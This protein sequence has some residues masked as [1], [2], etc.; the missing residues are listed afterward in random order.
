MCM[1][2]CMCMHMFERPPPPPVPFPPRKHNIYQLTTPSTCPIIV[3]ALQHQSERCSVELRSCKP[4]DTLVPGGM[5]SPPMPMYVVHSPSEPRKRCNG[6]EVI[7][8]TLHVPS[9]SVDAH[10]STC[11][12]LRC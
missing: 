8:T 2:M 11:W 10:H 9:Y 12:Y 6:V 7:G 4:S 3:A 5:D 1:C